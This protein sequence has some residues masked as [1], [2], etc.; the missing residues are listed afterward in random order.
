MTADAQRMGL[1]T[2]TIG[3]LKYTTGQWIHDFVVATANKRAEGTP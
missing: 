2:T 3:R 1:K